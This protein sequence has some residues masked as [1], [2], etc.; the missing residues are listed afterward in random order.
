MLACSWGGTSLASENAAQSL[1]HGT[2]WHA[3][4]NI[5]EQLEFRRSTIKNEKFGWIRDYLFLG[6]S[7]IVL[8]L[9]LIPVL[10]P[11][12]MVL[13][14]FFVFA[15][16]TTYLAIKIHHERKFLKTMSKSRSSSLMLP[17]KEMTIDVMAVSW[18][19]IRT[20]RMTG[21]LLVTLLIIGFAYLFSFIFGARLNA[22]NDSN[23]SIVLAESLMISVLLWAWMALAW[24]FYLLLGSTIVVLL[25]EVFIRVMPPRSH[26]TKRKILLKFIM[27]TLILYYYVKLMV[28]ILVQ[29]SNDLQF[30]AGIL[31]VYLS[32][33]PFYPSFDLLA[34]AT[35][36]ILF[37]PALL[38]VA[39][40]LGWFWWR[41]V[42]HEHIVILS[43][44]HQPWKRQSTQNQ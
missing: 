33:N 30:Q 22:R 17:E 9:T 19:T 2:I 39:V 5:E 24:F 13:F 26:L 37:L 34:F 20:L 23:F 7:I 35:L 11:S 14:T 32:S 31:S 29:G 43:R 6:E 42:V 41:E 4:S 28:I 15:A 3:P 16:A 18:S 1:T 8:L 25:H 44:H 12:W 10:G 40:L 36:D 27:T 21:V 38:A